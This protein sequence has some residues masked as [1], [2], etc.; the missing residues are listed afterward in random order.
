MPGILMSRMAR[1]GWSVADQLDR[2]VAA[3]GLADDLVALFLE[4]LAQIHPDDGFVFGDHDTQRQVV[5]LS[6]P[7]RSR[8]LHSI[9]S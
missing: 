5:F 2:L 1:S 8:A 4:G 3:A 7:G 6:V 9:R